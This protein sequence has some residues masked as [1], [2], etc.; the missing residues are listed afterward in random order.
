MPDRLPAPAGI[1]DV[2]RT[3]LP[4]RAVFLTVR[5]TLC[6]ARQ[7]GMQDATAAARRA[8]QQ[9]KAHDDLLGAATLEASW[10]TVSCLELAAN[11]AA[12][13]VDP[14][15]QSPHGRWS[16]TTRYD[17]TRVNRFYESSRNWTDERF[18]ALSGHRFYD[19]GGT[20]MVDTLKE[21]GFE[22]ERFTRAFGEAEAATT[23]FLR[24]R[25]EIL[26]NAWQFLK[27]YAAS[28]EHGLLLVPSKYGDA[29]NSQE[30]V[31]PQPLIVWATRKDAALWPEGHTTEEIIDFAEHVGGLA[32]DL[33]DY[34]ADCRLRLIE[35]LD[36]VG[37]HVYLK[38]FRNPIPYWV[39]KGDLP[40]ETLALLDGMSINWIRTEPTDSDPQL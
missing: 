39:T 27:A 11:V 28:Y 13:W 6:Q 33:A 14:Q 10:E 25:F 7:L 31:I 4:S 12:P 5:D 22:D 38:N 23:R 3:V 1:G 9:P 35:A 30:E 19:S 29:V 21:A 24:G 16:E 36:F 18:A 2:E 15:L 40:D 26:A 8:L 20:S 17:P 34:V 32:I 37:G